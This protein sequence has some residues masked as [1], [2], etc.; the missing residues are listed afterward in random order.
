MIEKFLFHLHSTGNG[1]EYGEKTLWQNCSLMGAKAE[2]E[3]M[4]NVKNTNWKYLD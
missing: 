1:K 4:S 2:F 3:V